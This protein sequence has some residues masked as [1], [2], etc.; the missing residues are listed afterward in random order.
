LLFLTLG[1]CLTAAVVSVKKILTLD[2]AMV[3]KG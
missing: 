1:M 2:P 3:F